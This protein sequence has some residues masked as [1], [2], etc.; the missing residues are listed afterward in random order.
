MQQAHTYNEKRESASV[1]LLCLLLL[2]WCKPVLPLVTDH[3][4]HAFFSAQ[5][6]RQHTYGVEHLTHD[7]QTAQENESASANPS[8]QMD[9]ALTVLAIQVV[10]PEIPLLSSAYRECAGLQINITHP[11]P[12]AQPPDFA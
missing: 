7:L 4:A 12:Q 6:A 9:N 1:L 8:I 5:H 10:M 2:M 11:L 3:L